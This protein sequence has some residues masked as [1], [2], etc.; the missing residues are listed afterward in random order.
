I[1]HPNVVHVEELGERDG[2]YYLVMEFVEGCA[3]AQFVRALARMERRIVP[4]LA[5]HIAL[6][7]ADGLHA[8]HATRG[9][10][11]ELLG[12]VQRD[13]SPHN[14]LV[15]N[16]GYIKLIDF[17]IAKARGRETTERGRLRGKLGYM[18][19]EQAHGRTVDRRAD[20]YALGLVLWELLT[21]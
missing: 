15:S 5:V 13:V 12:V 9:S 7:A 3:V 18:S 17:G 11:G 2:T 8:A 10:A 1:K 14:V 16:S 21:L 6:E 19:P 4:E 20:I